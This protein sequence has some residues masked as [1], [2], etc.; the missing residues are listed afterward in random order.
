MLKKYLFLLFFLF[1]STT[2]FAENKQL[3]IISLAPNITELLF[4]A[5]AGKK[6]VGVM[7]Y[8]DYPSAAKKIPIVAVFDHLDAERI[9]LLKP[10]IIFASK[11]RALS[12]QLAALSLPTVF[13]EIQ[14]LLDIPK[15][16]RRIGQIVGTQKIAEQ[17]AKSF[18]KQYQKLLIRYQHVKKITVFY[19]IWSPPLLT[20]SQNNWINDV[21]DL[22]GGQ[23]IFTTLM[24]SAPSVGMESVIVRRPQVILSSMHA[25]WQK[26]WQ[27]WPQ[28]PAVKYHHLFTLNPDLIERPGP[29]VLKGARQVCRFL[30]LVRG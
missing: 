28:I 14:N 19:E 10:D 9:L 25:N 22:C 24:G 17:A 4:A 13:I 12:K 2:V 5:G 23:N 30:M 6:I 16:L 21:I 1:F 8:S 26:A 27:S 7:A 15:Q 11:T 18:E 29:R 3:R 20:I